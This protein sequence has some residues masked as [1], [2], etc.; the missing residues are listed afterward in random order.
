MPVEKLPGGADTPEIGALLTTVM[1]VAAGVSVSSIYYNQPLL[2]LIEAGFPGRE[3]ATAL[4]PTAN[5]LGFAFGLLLLV[6]LG[7]RFER[8]RLV[9]GQFA[10][11]VF[12]LA[13]AALAPGA[14]TLLAASVAVGLTASVTQQIVPFAAD[15]APPAH[16]GAII[17]TV[18]SGVLCGILLGRVVGGAVGDWLG[19][20]AAYGIGAGVAAASWLALAAVL[21]RRAASVSTGYTALMASLVTLWR[22]L[23]ALRRAAGIQ[24]G[25]F[26]SFIAFWSVFALY[27]SHDL[28]LGASVAGAFGIVGLV[29]VLFAPLAGRIADHRGPHAVIGLGAAT[30]LAAWLVFGLWRDV[31]GLAVGVVLLDFG[32]QGAMICNQH[33]IYALRPEARNRIN[34]VYMTSMFFTAS[35]GSAVAG[36]AWTGSG[37]SAV[38]LLGGALAAVAL[39]VHL[40]GRWRAHRR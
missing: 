31:A 32:V 17:G 11:L 5:Q 10:A 23:P 39:G 29:G 28:G 20:R 22:E 6:P 2:A 7:D 8:R 16:R 27:L 26:A 15:L 30:V 13:A 34:T 18:M 35:A 1:A 40:Q 25:L 14:G 4:V 37:W 19:W 33:I 9:L 21:P 38:S 36:L 24:A 12:A 3:S